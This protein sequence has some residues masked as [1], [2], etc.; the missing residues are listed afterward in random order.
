MLLSS[1]A[2][3]GAQTSTISNGHSGVW[4]GFG[5]DAANSDISCT[6][7]TFTGANDPWRGGLGTGVQISVGGTVS[8]QMLIGAE[9]G[10]GV[11]MAGNGDRSA[12]VVHLMAVAQYYPDAYGGFFVRGGIGPA[13]IELSDNGTSAKASGF[14]AQ[15]GVGYDFHLGKRVA[16]A[17]YANVGR[18]AVQQSSLRLSGNTGP[19]SQLDAKTYWHIG[20]SV[21]WY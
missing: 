1:G 19:V 16:L 13:G 14:A 21:N 8:P 6:G 20:L 15:A 9:L 12:S 4:F 18:L 10:G 17:P 7:C 2:A 11:V 3:V 5:L